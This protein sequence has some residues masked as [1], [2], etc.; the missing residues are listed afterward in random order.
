MSKSKLK[1]KKLITKNL[2]KRE[3]E[4]SIIEQKLLTKNSY[5]LL[6][7]MRFV[8]C[9]VAQSILQYIFFLYNDILN[10]NISV[11]FSTIL[12]LNFD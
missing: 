7:R 3:L 5:I 4:S 12:K 1:R 10:Y 9:K 11:E 6:Y 2:K 8:N